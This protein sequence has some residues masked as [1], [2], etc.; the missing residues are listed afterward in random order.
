[1]FD[2]DNHLLVWNKRYQM[3]YN[4]DPARIWRGCTIRDLLAARVAA[5][6]FPLDSQK[7]E[8]ALRDRLAKGQT[9]TLT[10]QLSDGRIV[11]VVNQPLKDGGWVATH[12][13]I[14][15]GTRAER[16]CSS[17]A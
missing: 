3:M 15:E 6:T 8:A 11:E 1:M 14:T 4:I 2:A 17:T 12:E 16:A 5:G 13:D 7:Y 9:F 10:V